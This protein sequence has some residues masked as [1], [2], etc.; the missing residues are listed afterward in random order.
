MAINIE[1]WT[2]GN[3]ENGDVQLNI[4]IEGEHYTLSVHEKDVRSMQNIVKIKPL[5]GKRYFSV[6]YEGKEG[7]R[8]IGIGKMFFNDAIEQGKQ[9]CK[10][11]NVT[12]IRIEKDENY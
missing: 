5:L 9:Y 8:K 4:F 12:F 11:N 1:T 10:K 3:D 6:V 7:I 2:I